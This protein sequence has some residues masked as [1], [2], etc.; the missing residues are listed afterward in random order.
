MQVTITE[1]KMERERKDDICDTSVTK[2]NA[3]EKID[4]MKVTA[5]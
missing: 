4:I 1:P 5:C 3:N 2:N